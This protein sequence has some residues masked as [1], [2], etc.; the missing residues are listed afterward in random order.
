MKKL[1]LDLRDEDDGW[2]DYVGGR[3][4]VEL[5]EAN[6]NHDERGRFADVGAGRKV[7]E[8][9]PTG[10][11]EEDRLINV[12]TRRESKKQRAK[13]L[14]GK[15]VDPAA[16][17]ALARL[18]APLKTRQAFRRSGL[19]L[20]E[21]LYSLL[22]SNPYHVPS[23]PEGG[24]F[25]SGGEGGAEKQRARSQWGRENP[26][27]TRLK[28]F[29]LKS[30]WT[31]TEA[32]YEKGN[33]L[34][35]LND[36]GDWDHSRGGKFIKSTSGL[37][38]LKAHLAAS[39]SESNP[40][41]VPS[42]PEGGQFTSGGGGSSEKTFYSVSGSQF[43]YG[44]G[45]SWET[46]KIV[47]GGLPGIRMQSFPQSKNFL[48]QLQSLPASHLEAVRSVGGVTI[49]MDS[50]LPSRTNG[51]FGEKSGIRISTQAKNPEGT[52]IHEFGHALDK[53][54]ITIGGVSA[55]LSSAYVE[56]VGSER[57]SR[58]GATNAHEAFAEAYA[59]YASLPG[60]AYMEKAAPKSRAFME[61]VFRSDL[62][63]QAVVRGLFFSHKESA[64]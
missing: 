45:G 57:V 12:F 34:I 19:K 59:M 25:T 20:R 3:R 44:Y 46:A 50:K 30:G 39:L 42:G 14:A 13:R 8:T 5:A 52:L 54:S 49:S 11:T 40:Y 26:A 58:Y 63:K 29:L 27:K 61:K 53:A 43:A 35:Y 15:K 48:A 38:N 37:R 23:G 24:Q 55:R 17:A 6:P 32:G 47:G 16:A 22:E 60:R 7:F 41:H 21:A 31:R 4:P 56:A 2:D 62:S 18:F 33:D 64:K 10:E 51:E 9:R 36:Y 1:S 28:E